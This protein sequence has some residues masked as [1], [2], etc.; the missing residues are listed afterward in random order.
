M[1]FEKAD[2]R[3]KYIEL[4]GRNLTEHPFCKDIFHYQVISPYCMKLIYT[5]QLFDDCR[6]LIGEMKA[7]CELE[8]NRQITQPQLDEFMCRLSRAGREQ[9]NKEAAK[10]QI[11]LF[12]PQADKLYLTG[13]MEDAA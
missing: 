11:R 10:Y 3:V 9:F 6:E 8:S 13:E 12:I 7:V 2:V 5:L 4:Q 1:K